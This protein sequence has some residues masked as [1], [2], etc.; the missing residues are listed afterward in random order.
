MTLSS[1][2]LDDFA[3]RL[4]AADRDRTA[5][6]NLTTSHPQADIDDAYAISTRVV[7]TLAQTDPVIGYK[8]GLTSKAAQESAGV[9]EPDYGFLRRSMLVPDGGSLQSVQLF[10]ASAEPELA[11][12][13]GD[14]F[15]ER[16][17][18]AS[19]VRSATAE[20]ALALEIIDSRYTGPVNLI[21][22]IADNASTGALVLG[23]RHSDIGAAL[24][25]EGDVALV[26]DDEIIAS[27]QLDAVMGDPA[28]AVAWLANRLAAYGV[29]FQPGD[30][31]L[32]G[33]ITRFMP[34]GDGGRVV[35]DFGPL[36]A[37]SAM[38]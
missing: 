33:S 18:T 23:A 8:I 4:T 31:V 3:A 27:G 21:D 17:V 10:R 37:V 30:I 32:S 26:V 6:E 34:L 25:Y 1:T 12:I 29:R 7:E 22:S 11:F 13:I 19:D 14:E 24:A 9:N 2:D 38:A 28:V 15:P 20:I 5:I 36:G 35:A 16:T